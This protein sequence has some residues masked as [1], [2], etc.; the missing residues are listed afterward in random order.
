MRNSVAHCAY[1]LL[2]RDWGAN[3]ILSIFITVTNHHLQHEKGNANF[4][5]CITFW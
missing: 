4:A 1:E 5:L 2:L 3:R